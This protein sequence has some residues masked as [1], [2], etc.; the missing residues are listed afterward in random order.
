MN[1]MTVPQA[2]PMRAIAERVA[3]LPA[4]KR[5]QFLAQLEAKG[6]SAQRLPIVPAP[7]GGDL[8]LSHAQRRL[9][10]LWTLEPGS[11]AYHITGGLRLT[12]RLDEA[13]LQAALDGLVARHEALRTIFPEIDS[14]PLQRILP[15][16]PL[17]L[18]RIDLSAVPEGE[19]QDRLDDASATE[20]RQTF[21]LAAGPLLR[22]TLV[23]LA[24]DEH[25]LLLTLHHI[26][27]DGWSLDLLVEDLVRGYDD[28]RSGR[29]QRAAPEIQYADYAVWQRQ[30]MEAGEVERLLAS[31]VETLGPEQPVLELPA[32][33]PR[34]S[35][36][37]WR[38]DTVAFDLP[39]DLSAALRTLAQQQ[40]ATLF[41]VLLAGFSALL[42]RLGGQDDLRI[43]VPV[44][45]RQRQD[46]EPVVGCFVNT[47]VLPVRVDGRADFRSLLA[48][49]RDTALQAQAHQ[50]LPFERLVEALNPERSLS[51]NPLFQVM[52]QHGR[53]RDAVAL[54]LEDV[55]A[56]T[57]SRPGGSAQFDLSLSTAEDGAGRISAELTYAA[58]LFD[59]VT[60]ERWRDSFLRLLRQ[61]VAHPDRPLARLDLLT[62]TERERLS[63]WNATDRAHEPVSSV[64]TLIERQVRTKPEAEALVFGAERLSYAELDGRANRLAQALVARG[65][66]PDVLVGVAV[67]RSV[68]L[69]VAL[70]G[71]LKAGGAYLP[72]DPEY[73]RERLAGT[74]AETGLR[75]V[76]AQTRLLD[77]LPQADGVEIVTLES[78]DLS[79]YPDE[80]PVVAWHP[81]ALAYCI[82]TSGSTGKPKTVMVRHG[83]LVNLVQWSQATFE[84]SGPPV[85]LQKTVAGFDASVWEFFWPLASGGRLVLARPGGHRE[86]DHLIEMI[87]AEAVTAVQFVP[88]LLQLFLEEEGVEGC[89]SLTDVFCGGGELTPGLAALFRQRLPGARLHNLYGPT[90]TTVDVTSW[91]CRPEEGQRS[92]PIGHAI[93][94]TRIRVLDADLNPVPEGVA[95][96]LY[97]AGA[98]L[99]RGYLGRPDLT[100]ERFVPDPYGSPGS[101]MYRSGDR[102]R[103]RG[104][105][106]IEYVGRLDHQVKLRGLRIELGEMEAGLR[107]YPGIREAVVLLREGR[108][109]GYVAGDTQPDEAAV[110]AHLARTLPD[111]MLPAKLVWLE[112][113]PVSANGKLDRKA[114]PEPEWESAADSRAE[115]EGEAEQAI[116]AIWAEVL[117]LR[118]VG[119]D[120]NFFDR[121]GDS[122][123][124]LQVIARARRQ[125]LVLTLRDT[126]QHQ[127]V[128]A[129]AAAARRGPTPATAV[130]ASNPETERPARLTPSDLPLAGLSQAQIDALPIPAAEVAD[131]YPLS[132]LQQGLLFHALH[133][134]EAGLYVNQVLAT[135]DGPLDAGRFT[136]AWEA[137]IRRHDILRTGFL[138]DGPAPLQLVLRSVP[139]PVEIRDGRGLDEPGIAEIARWERER[140]F[141]LSAPPLMRVLLLRM[142]EDRHRLIWTFHHILMDGWSTS[143]LIGEVLSQYHG[144]A[145]AAGPGRYR[146]HIAWLAGRDA[147]ADEAFWRGQLARLDAPTRLADALPA[148]LE[149]GGGHGVLATRREADRTARLIAFCRRERI[150]VNTLVQGAWSLLLSRYT[151]Q[152][153]VAF[154][155]TVAGRPAELPG[156][157]TL[158]GLFINTLPVIQQPDPEARVGD[159]LRQ[160]Q[161]VMLAL[162]E[163]E[164]TPLADIQRWGGQGGLFDTLLVFENYPIDRAAR[165]GGDLRVSAAETMEATHYPLSLA[166]Q[167]GDTLDIAYGY[168]RDAFTP[169]QVEALSRHL[170]TLL[171]RLIENAG[172]ELGSLSMLAEADLAQLTIWQTE[173]Y[174]AEPYRPV[175]DWISHWAA[176]EP[177]RTAVIFGDR[178]VSRGELERRANHLAHRLVQAGVG[179]DVLVGVVLERSVELLVAL[180]AVL[181]AGGAYVPLAPDAPAARLA[182]VAADSGLRLVL[183]QAS[184]AGRLPQGLERILVEDEAGEAETGPAVALHPENL[185]YVIYTSGST[186]K[187]KGVAVAHGP[188]A[189]HCRVTAPLY[190]MDESSR[191]FHFIAFSFDGAHERWLTALTCGA[192]LVLRDESLWPAEKTLAAIGRHGVTNAGFPPVYINEMAA[193]AEQTGQYPPV[194]LYSFGGEA[195]PAAGYDRVRRALRPR[196]LINGYGPTEAVVTPLVWKGTA[197][198]ACDGAYVPIGRPVGDR[199]AY[200][201]D[202][203][204]QPVP[205]G[206]AG[207]LYIGG[208]GLA[209]G[210]VGRPDL[211]AE[212]FVPDPYGEPGSR[213]YRTGDVVR[214]RPDGAIDYL[215]RADHQVKIRGYRIEPGEIEA[216]LL[217]HP[218]VRGAVASAMA[219]PGGKRLVAHVAAPEAGEGLEAELKAHL[220]GQLPE[221]MVP[222]R[223]L[224]LPAL[225]LLP[226]GK[227]D[228]KAL[229]EPEWESGSRAEPEGEAERVLAGIWAEVLGVPSVGAT[230]NFFELG[231]DSILSLQVVSRARRAGLVL[232]PRQLFEHQTVRGLAAVAG[233]EAAAAVEAAT[234]E[235]PLIP[236]QRWFFEA[237]IAGRQHWNQS[238]LLAPRERLEAEALGRALAAVVGHHAAL[239]LRF[240]QGTDGAWT[241]AYA[242]PAA[243][244]WLWLRSVADET[245]QAAVAEAAQRSLEL[246][247]GPLLRAVLVE[248]WDGTQRLLLAIHHLVVDG[249][250]W[251]I[252]LEDLQQAYGQVL[253]G[254]EI[255]LPETG[256][257]FGAWGRA[258]QAY[259][260]SPELLAELPYWQGVLDGPS[261][262]PVVRPEGANTVAQRAEHRQRFDAALTERLVTAGRVWRAGVEDLLLT[263]LA[264]ALCR[265]TGQA[266]ALVALEGHGREELGG[267]DLSRTVGWFTSLY[268][269]RLTPAE[270][271]EASLKAVKEQLRAVPNR[272]LGYGVLRYMGSE[273]VQAAL[274]GLPWPSVTF[275]YLGRFDGVTAGAF[276]LAA[277]SAGRDQSEGSPLGA[278]LV[279]NGRVAEGMLGLTWLYSAARHD[280]GTIEQLAQAFASELE[281]LVELC[282]A[283]G[284]GGL[285]PSDVPLAGL[286]QAELDA[287]PVPAAEI[288]D[289]YPLSPMQQ[290]M[291]FHSLQAPELYVT[292]LRVDVDGLDAGRFAQAWEAAVESH[293]ILR[294]GF[295]GQGDKPLQLVR[296]RVPSPVERLDW[297]GRPDLDEAL[298]ELAA[299]DRSRGFDLGAPPLLRV[300]LVRVAEDRHRLILTSHHLLLDGWSTSRLI[301]EVLTRYHGGT[302]APVAGRYRDYIAWLGQ[303]D[304]AADE[305]FWRERLSGVE[306]P[307]LL[308]S[309]L[310]A[311]EPEPGHDS[312]RL[313]LDSAATEALKAFARRERVTLNTVLQGGWALLLSRITGQ[314]RVVF[315]ATVSG[316]PAELRDAE[317]LLGL[318]INTLPVAPALD[319]ARSIGDWLRDLQAENAALREHEATPL[320][321]IQGWAG[322]G[323]RAL[324]DTILVVE[325]YPVD[326]ALRERDGKGL[327]F[328]QVANLETTNYALTL[329]VQAGGDLEI[330]WSWRRDAFDRNRIERLMRQLEALLRRLAEDAATPLGRIAL[331]TEE[332]QQRLAR[333]NATDV[334]YEPVPSVLSLIA[335]Q[336]RATPQAEALVFGA[337]RLSYAELDRRTNRLAQALAARGVGPDVLVGV[338]AER[339]VEMV[340]ALLGIAKAGGAYL[341]LDPEHPRERLAGTI[342]ETG[343]RLVLAQ[344]HLIDRLP[345]GVEAVAL[346]GW[347]LSGWPDEAPVVDWH[348]ESLAYSITTSGSTGKPKAVGNSHRG[349]LN[350]LQWMQAEYRIGPGDRVLQKTPYGF[351]VSVWEF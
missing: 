83:G 337:E 25:V 117:G 92:V 98:N 154:G 88:S 327:R 242:E 142:A 132:P 159:W 160:V 124:S 254:A 78:W 175:Q 167:A 187:P 275:N 246:G 19:R 306:E 345:D 181:K 158:L 139:L 5:R 65:V 350:R 56:E 318:F 51:R 114:L 177:G 334:A 232:T 348:P 213:M 131:A 347:D 264:R 336:A 31:W 44:A 36:P 121:G 320:Y 165:A 309:A 1:D 48:S 265:H 28:H 162:H 57:L 223:I 321:E 125:G 193:W 225:P 286:S 29:A 245:E 291:L 11:A 43:G 308:A 269:V 229:P 258:L 260:S 281:A 115:P 271:L 307:T 243:Q 27:A 228:R 26:V 226:T 102:V 141:D 196:A 176:A 20:V 91:A 140:G 212:R 231:G 325:N 145:P 63:V 289:L 37:S 259:A 3:A 82:T 192:S 170:D 155:A 52:M 342:A 34:P 86:P 110:K 89:S 203:R 285:T 295:L 313:R 24:A 303:R 326:Q 79:G 220:A 178:E 255:R 236:I 241:Q 127:T 256:S 279:V 75:L 205:V 207:E 311:P 8:P 339:S 190:D 126:F 329:T 184:L 272:G 179:P 268:P 251:R 134:T 128:R 164:H 186:G 185:A 270:D 189:M 338:A 118:Q 129:L 222:S 93:S 146:D 101:R 274:A 9:W 23:R 283:P 319:P 96:E 210:Y 211:T 224:V 182:E 41:M 108:L 218:Q 97:I 94:N 46:V 310:P 104:D 315:G 204:L 42:R 39:D 202:G 148:P 61:V 100:A 282:S 72:L 62:E 4:D 67:E 323:G 278:E 299:S 130:P 233:R 45:N 335:R 87:R 12:G 152:P 38:G 166:V 252:L 30:L 333:W 217:S 16:S 240:T 66:G 111:Y 296:R 122:I 2:D 248:R 33:R 17:V 340:V 198:T 50:A 219:S 216:R 103:R 276:A 10:L 284:A 40:G 349:L 7:R 239:R 168:R 71:I 120:D 234:G 150:T 60:V 312:A 301:G 328:G 70:L 331:P 105:G 149:K 273:E 138:W 21:D 81:E 206:V 47:Q 174:R 76:L 64:V 280:A 300:L 172:S 277:E 161:E 297:R 53:R 316:R 80:A 332:D 197:D 183:T 133:A 293:A 106:A 298:V 156:A 136:R 153:G 147:A 191:E 235:A 249:V 74:I 113:L 214:W 330:G 288:E 180:L 84:T 290:G 90:E 15:P 346:E 266:S 116:A 18:A 137:A 143:R 58:E 201:L 157:E 247:Q 208:G 351:D 253:A 35:E 144:T 261:G 244:D 230:D 77:R 209:R 267:L 13:A 257:G 324:F 95:G 238:V 135:F 163:H 85:L 215:G 55:Q 302:P 344:A 199:R 171:D 107:S 292:Q 112:R 49:V 109:V 195:M 250:S 32:D 22:A 237:A 322:Q 69:V 123:L 188:L 343:L 14:E 317:A 294:T 54:R 314:R 263:A 59:R 6:I 68:E 194:D 151:G 341:P 221:Y 287:L 169:A 304:Q 99:A 173:P 227:L 262:V 119:R 305:A 73:P 200:V